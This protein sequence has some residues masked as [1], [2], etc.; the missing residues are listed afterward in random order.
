MVNKVIFIGHLGKDPELHTFE[1]SG[2]QIVSF[3][4]AS[5]E[6]YKDKEGN[7]QEKTTWINC[8]CKRENLIEVFKKYVKKGDKIYIEGKL[9][10]RKWESDSGTRYITEV[11]IN[12][13]IMLGN[14]GAETNS[15]TPPP[16]DDDLP[17]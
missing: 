17:F 1:S 9:S 10:N 12:G 11:Y 4:L 5:T 16:E 15:E 6:K 8:I 13:L 2:N 3:P 14:K 7:K